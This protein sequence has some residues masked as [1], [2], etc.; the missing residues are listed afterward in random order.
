MLHKLLWTL[1][2]LLRTPRRRVVRIEHGHGT[3]D[4]CVLDCGHRAVVLDFADKF[5][6]CTECRNE[7]EA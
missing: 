2:T 4:Y 5:V 7:A 3:V 6:R 1:D